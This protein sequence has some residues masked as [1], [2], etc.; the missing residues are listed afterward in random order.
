MIKTKLDNLYQADIFEIKIR[1]NDVI[2]FSA[3]Y[4]NAIFGNMSVHRHLMSWPSSQDI[5]DI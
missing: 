2:R 3:F 4:L 5:S 1:Q